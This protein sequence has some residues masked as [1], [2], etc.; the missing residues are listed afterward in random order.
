MIRNA[1]R[2]DPRGRRGPSPPAPILVRL[3]LAPTYRSIRGGSVR[4]QVF[5]GFLTDSGG[6]KEERGLPPPTPFTR[7]IGVDSGWIRSRLYFSILL[8]PT[9]RPIQD[10]PGWELHQPRSIYIPR[11]GCS[12][13]TYCHNC[14]DTTYIWFFHFSLH[15]SDPSLII[16]YFRFNLLPFHFTEL[17]KLMQNFLQ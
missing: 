9:Y 16:P 5:G 4:K 15:S 2:A 8:V 1:N 6:S 14:P 17:S 7:R 3:L 12:Q 13:S 10:G 11:C